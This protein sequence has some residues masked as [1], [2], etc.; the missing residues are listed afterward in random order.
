MRLCTFGIARI[1]S[2]RFGNIRRRRISFFGFER[3]INEMRRAE[4]LD[5][6]RRLGKHFFQFVICFKNIVRR[7]TNNIPVFIVFK[8]KIVTNLKYLCAKFFLARRCF[9]FV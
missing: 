4:K 2:F 7:R 5:E 6:N 1:A 3:K 9:V 8:S